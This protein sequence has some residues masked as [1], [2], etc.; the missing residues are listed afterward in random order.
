MLQEK[1]IGELFLSHFV[2]QLLQLPQGDLRRDL[3]PKSLQVLLLLVE[4]LVQIYDDRA[5]EQRP[6]AIAHHVIQIC[7]IGPLPRGLHRKDVL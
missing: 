2:Q 6:L 5:G 7:L 1:G 3:Q 4:H